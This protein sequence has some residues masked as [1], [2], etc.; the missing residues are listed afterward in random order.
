MPG[1]GELAKLAGCKPDVVKKIFEGVNELVKKGEVVSIQGL[2]SFRMMDRKA[3]TARNPQNGQKL[4]VP[5][6]KRM[7]FAAS[8]TLREFLNNGAAGSKATP[9][10]ADP[11]A[12]KA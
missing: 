6:Q 5:A 3:T 4:N 12:P 2:G 10:P 11:A 7:K 8:H 9:V 1:I